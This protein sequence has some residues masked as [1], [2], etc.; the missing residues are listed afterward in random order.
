MKNLDFKIKKGE[1][2]CVIGAI[3]SGKSS[4]LSAII[5]E[6][7]GCTQQQIDSFN[8]YQ[9]YLSHEYSRSPI[10]VNQSISYS[11]QTPWIQNKTIRE[12]IIFGKEYNRADYKHVIKICELK[13][14]LQILP[15]GD[16]TEIGEKGI[17][18]SG[19]QK[20]RVSLARAVYADKDI[21]LMDDPISALDANV[22]KKI[23]Q[24]V[25]LDHLK[26]KTRILVTHAVDFLHLV[27]RIFVMKDGELVLE[28]KYDDIKD[29]A[30][31]QQLLSIHKVNST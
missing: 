19:G 15:S 5:G 6:L 9:E 20:A 28:G 12:N 1:F 10:N 21:I 25:L 11:Q 31:L 16:K 13:R 7:L 30:Y 17:N 22:K 8:P 2:I 29:N 24:N 23:F 26:D 4:L 27:D 18:L 3:G 14:D